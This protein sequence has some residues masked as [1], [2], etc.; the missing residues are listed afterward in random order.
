MP[1]GDFTAVAAADAIGKTGMLGKV[2]R[3][4]TFRLPEVRLGAQDVGKLVGF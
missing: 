1:W 2:F 4:R 3:S